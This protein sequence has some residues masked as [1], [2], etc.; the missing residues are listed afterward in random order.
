VRGW[1]LGGQGDKPREPEDHGDNLDT[2]DAVNM[3]KLSEKE[4][5]QREIWQG[6][7][8]GPDGIEKH[9][10]DAL[11]RTPKKSVVFPINHYTKLISMAFF[12]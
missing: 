1:Q 2:Q 5:H 8:E 12:F 9:E 4:G 7:E 6:N 10:V 11:P 3:R